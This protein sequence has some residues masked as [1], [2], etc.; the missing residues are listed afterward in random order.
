MAAAKDTAE[1]KELVEELQ[2]QAQSTKAEIEALHNCFERKGINSKGTMDIFGRR[3]SVPVDAEHKAT[4]MPILNFSNPHMRAFHASWF[5]FFSTF[6]STFAAAPLM[7]Y[8]KKVSD[9]MPD[10]LTKNDIYL[11]NIMSVAG[12]IVARLIMGTVCDVMGARKGLAFCLFLTCPFIIGIM[13][14][15]NAAGFI[16]CRLFIGCGLA[17]FVACQVWCTQQFSKKIVGLANATAGGWGNLGGGITNLTMVF[18]FKGFLAAT[19]NEDLSWRLCFLVPLALHIFSGIL[20]LSGR[21]LPDGNFKE[22]EASGAKQKSSS[23]I[24]LKVGVSNVNAWI[25]TL[26]YGFCF[27]VELTMTNV[28]AL[29]FYEYHGMTPLL[30]SVFAS[31]F[32]LVNLCARSLGGIWSDAAS[33]KYG[34]R[35][36][37]WSLWF[38][39]SVEGALCI[40]M[41]I[42]TLKYDAPVDGTPMINGWARVAATWEE[43]G[44]ATFPGTWGHQDGPWTELSKPAGY[45][46]EAF[47]KRYQILP[48]G[49]YELKFTQAMK[50]ALEA[51]GN[52][53]WTNA[54]SL[55]LTQAP[56]IGGGDDC[57]SNSGTVGLVVLIMFLFSIA[58]QMAEG[59]T[60]GVV[61]YVSRPA[62]GVVSG[63]V[64]AGGNLGAVIATSVFFKGSEMRTDD[65][66]LYLGITILA[67]TLTCFGL[68]FPDEGGMLF[69]AGAIKYDPQIIKPPAGYRG[70]DSMNYEDVGDSTAVKVADVALEPVG[71]APKP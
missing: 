15:T 62:L 36:R 44:D 51:A 61:P 25:L 65:G 39:Q 19:D 11:A 38:W 9:N 24:V 2:A 29:Y 58:V 7:P 14:V 57:I 35:G 67:V 60:F 71:E 1:L 41:A 12:T 31:I 40:V 4:A 32:G 56:G 43:D 70:A 50:D 28:A 23:G 64:G 66:I 27:G 59:L 54:K 5:G 42:V 47:D 3:F 68:Y 26:T 46:G 18:I 17:S 37:I 45:D 69:G 55:V 34:M 63:M 53:N 49:S 21:D 16:T 30:S 13:F 20:A 33:A 10:G 48:C 52:T 22:L 6:F 8:I